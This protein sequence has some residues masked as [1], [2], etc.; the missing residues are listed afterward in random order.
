MIGNLRI[1][2]AVLLAALSIAAG[3]AAEPAPWDFVPAAAEYTI[4]WD[5][6][7]LRSMPVYTPFLRNDP[8][9]RESADGLEKEFGVR[10]EDLDTVA[11]VGGGKTLRGTLFRTKIPEARLTE[12]LRR[13][14]AKQRGT[15]APGRVG[16]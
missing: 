4:V 11:F 2:A 13:A 15:L 9:F 16:A 1:R 14:A 8:R 6:V 3:A 5:A 7:R 12:L 10:F